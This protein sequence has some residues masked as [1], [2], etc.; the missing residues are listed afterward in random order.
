MWA[1][2]GVLLA[3]GLAYFL[4]LLVAAGMALWHYLLIKGRTREGC[5]KAFR[6]NHWL[7][8]AVFVGLLVDSAL[9]SL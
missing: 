7:G 1:A 5:F 8:L 2:A 6:L 3:L 9:K 4:G